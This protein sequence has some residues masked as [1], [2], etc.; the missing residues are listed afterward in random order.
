MTYKNKLRKSYFFFSLCSVKKSSAQ[1]SQLHLYQA[2]T[3]F[4]LIL[5]KCTQLRVTGSGRLYKVWSAYENRILV[6]YPRYYVTDTFHMWCFILMSNTHYILALIICW[7]ITPS[8]LINKES[9]K[10]NIMNLFL[11]NKWPEQ[12]Q[13]LFSNPLMPCILTAYPIIVTWEAEQEK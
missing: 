2:E 7:E 12:Q 9:Y 1:K 4:D 11:W 5:S 8:K 13:C 10:G 6:S 3:N